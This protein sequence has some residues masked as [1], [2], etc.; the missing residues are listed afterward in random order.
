M[1]GKK[2]MHRRLKQ[3]RLPA[4][5]SKLVSLPVY[6][7]QQTVDESTVRHWIATRQ[8]VAYKIRGRW[9]IDPDSRFREPLYWSPKL[10]Q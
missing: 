1:P 7:Q 9:W 5:I 8:L 2:R 6:C 3:R 4:D 10:V